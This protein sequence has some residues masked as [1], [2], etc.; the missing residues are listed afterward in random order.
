MKEHIEYIDA[1]RGFAMAMVVVCHCCTLSMGNNPFPNMYL[2]ASLQIPLFFMISGFFASKM[3]D[4]SFIGVVYDKFISL[5]LPAMIMLGLYCWCFSLDFI[6]SLFLR[7]K[8]GYW[9]TFV[10]FG[11]VIIFMSLSKLG[12]WMGL[13]EKGILC[14]HL[15]MGTGVSEVAFATSNISKEYDIFNL[16]IHNRVL[17]LHILCSRSDAV[18][19][20]GTGNDV[21]E[22]WE[23]NRNRNFAVS[24]RSNLRGALWYPISTFWSG[25]IQNGN[26]IHTLVDHMDIV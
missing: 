20:Q 11:Y 25:I 5:V 21:F 2:N 7:Y 6:E 16:I 13:S 24:H 1:M 4:R 12:R 17:Q 10:L 26:T 14:F 15:V 9:F 23:S 3:L 19:S 22:R 8:E 18:S